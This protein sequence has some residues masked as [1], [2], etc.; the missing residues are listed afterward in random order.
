MA[1]GTLSANRSAASCAWS[2]VP[3]IGV[4]T[5]PAP[6][7]TV[8]PPPGIGLTVNGPIGAPSPISCPSP[9]SAPCV[10]DSSIIVSTTCS[11]V[12]V[13]KDASSY[14]ICRG[15][16]GSGVIIPFISSSLCSCLLSTS[17]FAWSISS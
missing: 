16:S 11:G 14:V 5:S 10:T 6:F 1:S 8:K 13:V 9:V 2:K 3:N 15:A 12:S 7:T 17:A 4:R